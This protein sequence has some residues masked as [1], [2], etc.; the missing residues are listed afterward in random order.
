[1]TNVYFI[2]DLH[3]G[4]KNVL[5]FADGYRQGSTVDEHDEWLLGQIA[6]VM[7]KRDI[8][9]VLGDVAY[10]FEKLKE[11]KK[12]PGQKMLVRG[13]H[14]TFKTSDYLDVFREV[15][16]IYKTY[17]MWISHCPIHPAEL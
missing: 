17:G 14:D 15:Y 11:L 4:H 16:G 5:K 6:S 1:M 8:L 12:I 9:W 7:R 10:D 2:S 13:N 3:L